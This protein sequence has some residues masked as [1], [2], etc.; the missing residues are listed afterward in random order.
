MPARLA[1]SIGQLQAVTPKFE[2]VLDVPF[3]GVLFSLPALLACGLLLDIEKFFELP[4]GY[5]GIQSI[6]LMLAFMALARLKNPEAL[7]FY[8]PGEWGKLLG[9]D[10]SPEVRTLREKMG[11]LS[12][13]GQLEAWRAKLCA[14]WVKEDTEMGFL[15][16]V[17][18]HVRVYHGSQTPLPKHYVA[19]EKLC[20]RATVDYWVNALDGQPF[21]FV[22]KAVDP[23]LIQ[24][25]EK[26]IV[27]QLE[28]QIPVLSEAALA[29]SPLQHRFTLVFD[30]EGYSPDLMKRL[31]EKRIACITYHKYPKDDWNEQEFVMHLVRR[32]SGNA[33]EVKLAE[34]GTLLS[35]K[36]WVREIRRLTETG[37]QISIL[38][39]DY[40]SEL[41]GI[42]A[43]MSDRWSQENFFKYM[44][45]HFNLDRLIDY[46]IEEINETT[47][48]VNPK[49]RKVE[50]EIRRLAALHSRRL[51][52]FGQL[53][54]ENDIEPTLVELYQQKKA[55]LQED[56]QTLAQKLDTAKKER[57]SIKRHICL[58][59]LPKEQ[60]FSRLGTDAK[61]F[62]DTI[63]MVAYRAETAMAN[64][65]R[66]KIPRRGEERSL[67]RALY[68]TECDLLPDE[69]NKT[70]T[71]Q[72]HHLANHY[73]DKLIQHL[74]DEL[75]ATRMKFPGTDLRL[76]YKMGT[77]QNPR[78]QVV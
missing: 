28:E 44:R 17:D 2:Q 23:G 54:L 74:C 42:A 6:F 18:G 53:H 77:L 19:R 70:L 9:L 15:F 29:S 62:I 14:H 68:Q 63:K 52:E 4:R 26:D 3:G 34:R 33:V 60:R 20:L 1:A 67:L 40:C 49:Y 43:E 59:E 5:Y 39:T 69:K 71:V 47:E 75:N 46:S 30:R 12:K 76:F 24:V 11:I 36:L 7:R 66:E 38:S 65:L 37:R 51:S 21:F 41:H 57:K 58:E 35:S 64:L 8:A 22:N 61:N 25:L 31:K 78:D 73:S 27:P 16:Y 10:R 13:Q 56:I 50:S 45:E 72:L 55:T 32:A 48:V